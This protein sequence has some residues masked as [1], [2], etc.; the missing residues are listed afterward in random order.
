MALLQL[1]SNKKQLAEPY[2][3][4]ALSGSTSCTDSLACRI[5]RLLSLRPPVHPSLVCIVSPA[6]S[7]SP[8]PA[9][10]R[11]ILSFLPWRWLLCSG[12]RP[13]APHPPPARRRRQRGRSVYSLVNRKTML[14]WWCGADLKGKRMLGGRKMMP[15]KGPLIEAKLA[16]LV[17]ALC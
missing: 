7:S 6:V 8:G 13:R 9:A 15:E 16:P 10:G 3:R 11:C 14:R 12:P 2:D 17:Y 1:L 5:F 4:C